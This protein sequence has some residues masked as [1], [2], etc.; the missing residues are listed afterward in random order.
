MVACNRDP[1]TDAISGLDTWNQA[2]NRR[3]L[4]MK[5][6]HKMFSYSVVDLRTEDYHARQSQCTSI[7]TIKIKHVEYCIMIVVYDA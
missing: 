6:N 5:T 7:H 1:L 2:E 3:K 4:I